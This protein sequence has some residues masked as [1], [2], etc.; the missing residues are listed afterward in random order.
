LKK[1]TALAFATLFMI[2]ALVVVFAQ[3]A[4]ALS[5]ESSTVTHL[6]I[7][8]ADDPSN[9]TGSQTTENMLIVAVGGIIAVVL[10]LT[11]ILLRV[12]QKRKKKLS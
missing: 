10:F 1:L 4:N 7:F 9:E 2:S 11:L 6:G 5:A 12:M 8:Q 3:P